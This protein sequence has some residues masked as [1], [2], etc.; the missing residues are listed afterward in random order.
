MTGLSLGQHVGLEMDGWL[1]FQ[2]LL[3]Q[4]CLYV[5]VVLV[6][7]VAVRE[8]PEGPARRLLGMVQVL[9]S[10]ERPIA[11]VL[12]RKVSGFLCQVDEERR[13]D[14]GG[15]ILAMPEKGWKFLKW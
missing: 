10:V 4:H 1:A 9:P 15:E 3:A 13:S 6:V 8:G 5:F 7:A 11:D 12:R 14:G 2:G